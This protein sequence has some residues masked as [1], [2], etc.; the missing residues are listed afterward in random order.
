MK[1]DGAAALAARDITKRYGDTCALD[2]VSLSLPDSGLIGLIGPNGAGKSTLLNILSGRIAP[3]EGSVTVH[4]FD[5]L[6]EA[7]RAR[8][9]LGFLPEKAPLY[10]EMTVAEYLSFQAELKRVSA[11]DRRRHIEEI[12]AKTGLTDVLNRRLGNLSKGFRQRTGVAQALCGNP[13]VILLDEPT[14]GLDPV[15]IHEF[16]ALMRA[17]GQQCLVILSTH[18]LSDVEGL[19]E[20]A[21][22]LNR[23]RVL[24]DLPLNGE[25]GGERRLRVDLMAGQDLARALLGQI[26]SALRVEALPGH[27]PGVASM[28]VYTAHDSPFERELQQKLVSAQTVLTRLEPVKSALEETFIAALLSDDAHRKEEATA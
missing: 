3:S 1:T 18:I 21:L 11:G 13:D 6:F 17:L 2:G 9:H 10:D 12:A 26:N 15:Q 19:C 23:G 28:L 27:S 14:A 5:V 8:P 4:G 7:D 16:R 20:R 25:E 22:I 24:R